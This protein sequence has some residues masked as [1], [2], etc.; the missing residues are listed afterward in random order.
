MARFA[1]EFLLSMRGALS[2]WLTRKLCAR[3]KPVWFRDHPFSSRRH[4][5]SFSMQFHPTRR[6]ARDSEG[7]SRIRWT[8]PSCGS[9]IIPSFIAFDPADTAAST[10]GY[11][12]TTY[13]TLSEGRFYG[14]SLWRMAVA[15]RSIGFPDATRSSSGRRPAL[16]G[17]QRSPSGKAR[18]NNTR[19]IYAGSF[20]TSRGWVKSG[21]CYSTA[22]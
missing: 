2:A 11:F 17:T 22:H 1:T 10:Y 12:H 20:F 18:S 4:K 5:V 9:P 6:P 3:P 7:A 16:R 19:A 15:S 21:R 8:E 14:C 13:P